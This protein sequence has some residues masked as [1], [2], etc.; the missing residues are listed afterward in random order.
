MQTPK[1]RVIGEMSQ[2]QCAMYQSPSG[3]S[4]HTTGMS[5]SPGWSTNSKLGTPGLHQ[6]Y[7]TMLHEMGH[8]LG[9]GGH[10]PLETDIMYE[11]ISPASPGELSDR[12]RATLAALYRRPIGSR[13][14]GA[15]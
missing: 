5:A 10:S 13:V 12:D 1:R 2:A 8:A 15:R 4:A 11:S 6:I 3:R 7:E 9:L 14:A